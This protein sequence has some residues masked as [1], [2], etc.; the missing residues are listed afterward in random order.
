MSYR[1]S[2]PEEAILP[3]NV[4]R[5]VYQALLM[6]DP[7]PIGLRHSVEYLRSTGSVESVVV[8]ILRSVEFRERFPNLFARYQTFPS[9]EETAAFHREGGAP[10]FSDP[11]RLDEA[12]R[13]H[14]AWRGE[15]V[16]A[17]MGY[18]AAMLIKPKIFDLDDPTVLPELDAL[19]IHVHLGG[20]SLGNKI[21]VDES[22][23]RPA[24]AE[25]YFSSASRN[26]I[27]FGP[28][29]ALRGELNFQGDNNLC[30]C[31]GKGGDVQVYKTFFYG[32]GSAFVFGIGSTCVHGS[33]HIEG[34]SRHIV[35]GRDCMLSGDVYVAATDNHAMVDAESQTVLN[36]PGDLRIG[37]HAWLGFGTTLLK[38]AHVGQGAVVAARSTVT[39]PVEPRTVAAGAPA[40]TIRRNVDW[41]RS[42]PSEVALLQTSIGEALTSEL[43]GITNPVG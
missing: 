27:V 16:L 38:G 41:A 18:P 21:V 32:S 39:R 37:P 20:R 17:E 11:I 3:E 9:M 4:I 25:L 23:S 43:T 35:V 31:S 6:R 42:L 14:P 2:T 13:N 10:D 33:F 29:C 5:G 28:Q 15:G 19:N 34:P 30:Y 22:L 40:R 36:M 7:D 24:R 12:I 8:G 1:P 26:L